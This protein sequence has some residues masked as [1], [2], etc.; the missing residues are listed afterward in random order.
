M[1]ERNDSKINSG[2]VLLLLFLATVIVQAVFVVLKLFHLVQWDWVYVLIPAIAIGVALI[3]LLLFLI[4]YIF[5]M[6]KTLDDEQRH[7]DDN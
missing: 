5:V 7:S 1:V 4:F 3:A 2:V 6:T